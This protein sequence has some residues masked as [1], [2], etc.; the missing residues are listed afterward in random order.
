MIA[1]YDPRVVVR[2]VLSAL[3]CLGKLA[4]IDSAALI[5]FILACQDSETGAF[6]P[7]LAPMI[8]NQ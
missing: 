7:T 4:W 2:W 5:K 1:L 3:D 6:G 8:M